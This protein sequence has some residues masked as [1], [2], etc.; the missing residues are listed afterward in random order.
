MWIMRDKDTETGEAFLVAV[1]ALIA[2]VVSALCLLALN[3]QEGFALPLLEYRHLDQGQ[4][5]R[6]RRSHQPTKLPAGG[7]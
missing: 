5:D 1:C 7:A 3:C 2:A 6:R 4:L